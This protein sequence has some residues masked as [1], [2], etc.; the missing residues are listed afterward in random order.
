MTPSLT[1]ELLAG[2]FFFWSLALGRLPM[3]CGCSTPIHIW[4]ALFELN[5]FLKNKDDIKLGQG[6]VGK[7]RGLEEE[8]RSGIIIFHCIHA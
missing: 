5:G 4:A 8:N 6:C 7:G 1:M 2:S 3:F